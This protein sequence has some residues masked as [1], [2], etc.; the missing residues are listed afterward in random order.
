MRA[1]KPL[2]YQTADRSLLR[3]KGRGLSSKSSDDSKSIYSFPLNRST[4]KQCRWVSQ[5]LQPSE[6]AGHSFWDSRAEYLDHMRT[7]GEINETNKGHARHIIDHDKTAAHLKRSEKTRKAE[8]LLASLLGVLQ[9]KRY[10]DLDQ[11]SRGGDSS[12]YYISQ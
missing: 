4:R 12:E 2:N 9:S 11:G 5:W 6:V 1:S 8:E 7:I 3:V 10:K